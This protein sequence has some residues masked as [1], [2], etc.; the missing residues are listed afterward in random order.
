M[1]TYELPFMSIVAHVQKIPI[2]RHK[3]R[4]NMT[5]KDIQLQEIKWKKY[6]LVLFIL[7]LSRGM[8]FRTMWYVRPA[9]AQTSLRVLIRACASR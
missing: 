7:H 1:K 9:K 2:Y 6:I 4:E 3:T 8:R 5:L